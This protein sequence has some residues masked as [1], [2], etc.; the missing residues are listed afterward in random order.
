MTNHCGELAERRNTIKREEWRRGER[1]RGC[2]PSRKASGICESGAPPKA[3]IDRRG[4]KTHETATWIQLLIVVNQ[5][6]SIAYR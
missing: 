6:T 4:T 2:G 5:N 1:R 3:G